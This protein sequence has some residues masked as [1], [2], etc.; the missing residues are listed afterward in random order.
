MKPDNGKLQPRRVVVTGIGVVS[1]IGVGV[2]AFRQGIRTGASG[3]DLIRSFD[4]ESLPCQIAA[5]VKDF[6][7]L[8]WFEK[9]D[10]KKMDSFIH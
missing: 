7:P 2:E 6:D 9:K 10:I 8:R 5:E 3:V 1:P 4:P